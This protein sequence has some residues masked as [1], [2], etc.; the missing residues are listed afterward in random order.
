[1]EGGEEGA[2]VAVR[3]G[4][5]SEPAAE[6]GEVGVSMPSYKVEHVGKGVQVRGAFGVTKAKR[7]GVC[8]P[9]KRLG[10]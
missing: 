7:Q 8:S 2:V 3:A 5:E 10:T 1:M 6:V 4:E 9:P